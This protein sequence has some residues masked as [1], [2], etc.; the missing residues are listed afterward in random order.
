MVIRSLDLSKV[1][2][3]NFFCYGFREKMQ[4]EYTVEIWRKMN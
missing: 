1:H 2:E 4:N 3:R